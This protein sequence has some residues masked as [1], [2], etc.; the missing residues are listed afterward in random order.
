MQIMGAAYVVD[1]SRPAASVAAAA[2]PE[3]GSVRELRG[4]DRVEISP[5]GLELEK[6]KRELS[7]LPD[8]RMDRVALARQHL[9]AGNGVAADDLAKKMLGITGD[10]R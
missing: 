1:L 6:L 8:V 9:Q 4:P 2:A 7:A 5:G 10:S 3:T